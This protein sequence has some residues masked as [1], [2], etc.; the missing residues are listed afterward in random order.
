MLHQAVSSGAKKETDLGGG[1]MHSAFID[2]TS[3]THCGQ[4]GD[5]GVVERL[6]G[7]VKDCLHNLLCAA[8][9]A[10]QFRIIGVAAKVAPPSSNVP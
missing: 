2:L 10:D 9:I 6:P 1:I 4:S 8:A 3:R 7:I 5:L